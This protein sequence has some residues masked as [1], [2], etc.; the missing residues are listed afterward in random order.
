MP[1][2]LVIIPAIM[3]MTF[4]ELEEKTFIVKD[5]VDFVQ[6]DIMDGKFTKHS[7]WPYK[8]LPDPFFEA[9]KTENKG[10]PYWENI[11]YEFDLMV[12]NPEEIVEDFLNAGASRIIIH[13]E[14]I[15]NWAK[16]IEN[17]KGKVEIGVAI[18]IATPNELLASF[19]QDADFIQC[20]G[21]TRIGFQGEPFDERV[22]E[23][24][25][26]IKKLYPNKIISVDGGVND[27]NIPELTEA[28]A[29]RLVEG[30]AFFDNL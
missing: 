20:M 11:N 3:P 14:T 8:K 7:S 30:T 5:L 18:N 27:E 1:N 6:V 29:S 26:E 28:G 19:V 22:I 23:K 2:N 9:I 13:V 10:L 24:V 4:K 12:E 17:L 21:I 15:K 16:I 25:K